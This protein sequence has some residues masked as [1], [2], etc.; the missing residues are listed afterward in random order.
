M[1]GFEPEAEERGDG[2]LV[3]TV[4]LL[5]RD[6]VIENSINDNTGIVNVNQAPGSMNN[7]ANLVS[8]AVSLV[9]P[10]EGGV[11]LSE[12]DLGQVNVGNQVYESDSDP[13][14]GSDPF[15]GIN[16]S[17]FFAAYGEGPTEWKR[18]ICAQG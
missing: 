17:A 11:A 18:V 6:A 9:S 15:L 1:N 7:Q 14:S 4:N 13:T 12:A 5:F 10:G 8:V 16:K 2:N 3:D